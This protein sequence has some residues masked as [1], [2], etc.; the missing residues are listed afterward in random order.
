M[1]HNKIIDQYAKGSTIKDLAIKYDVNQAEIREILKVQ[2]EETRLYTK[3]LAEIAKLLPRH[4]DSKA[5][6]I[7]AQK[8]GF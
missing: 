2:R 4:D 8:L 7:W 6:L 5:D 3:Q 1:N